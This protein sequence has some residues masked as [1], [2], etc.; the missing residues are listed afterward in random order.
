M[1][2]QSRPDLSIAIVNTNTRDLLRACLHS[3]EEHSGGLNIEIFVSDNNSSDGSVDMLNQE[4][5]AVQVIRNNYNAGFIRS[6]NLGLKR[7]R[8]RH[9]LLLNPDTVVKKDALKLMVDF[10]DDH[11]DVGAVG[12]RIRYGDGRLQYSA[13]TFPS[14]ATSIFNS[15][16]I[17]TTL[18]PNNRWSRAYIS[19]DEDYDRTRDV[20]WLSGSC[21]MVR[22]EVYDQIGGL[23]ERYFL[24]S[25][26]VDWCMEMKKHGWRRCYYHVPEIIHYEEQTVRKMPVFTTTHRHWSMWLYYRKHYPHGLL[27]IPLHAAVFTGITLRCLFV[28][29]KTYIQLKLGKNTRAKE[30]KA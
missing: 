29:A 2:N 3:V 20:D 25:D 22:R 16:S 11:P 5:P 19:R 28:L 13:R 14:L 26:D 9:L 12:P 4:F 8:G 7:A 6:T 27:R 15:K 17:L 10:L 1:E 24:Y 18:F 23:D 21:L 30:V